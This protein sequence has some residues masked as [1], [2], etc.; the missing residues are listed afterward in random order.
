[1]DNTK[2]QNAANFNKVFKIKVQFRFSKIAM[3]IKLSESM[4][5]RTDPLS[6]HSKAAYL[7]LSLGCD[8][9]CGLK[10]LTCNNIDG[11]IQKLCGQAFESLIDN[12][13]K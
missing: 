3:E 1:M 5:V 9:Y 2:G 11:V 6:G 8:N 4:N 10:N 12:L 7:E 13:C